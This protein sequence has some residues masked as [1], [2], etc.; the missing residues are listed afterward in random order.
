MNIAN[1]GDSLEKHRAADPL[2][3]RA[4]RE[5]LQRNWP[6]LWERARGAAFLG[7]PVALPYGRFD[8]HEKHEVEQEYLAS[9]A[10]FRDGE[11]FRVPGEFIVATASA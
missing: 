5:Y 1:H 10:G 6:A 9:L 8:D 11:G 2:Y 3:A 4:Q 7:G